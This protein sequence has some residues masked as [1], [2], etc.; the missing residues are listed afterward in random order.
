M[1]ADVVD[2]GVEL[3]QRFA[4]RRV[5]GVDRAVAVRRR[6]DDAVGGAVL[7]EDAHLDHRLRLHLFRSVLTFEAVTPALHDPEV[8]EVESL[9]VAGQAAADQQLQRGVGALVLVAARLHSL[10]LLRQAPGVVASQGVADAEVGHLVEQAA[11]A[12]ELG[13]EQAPLVADGCRVDVL[14]GGFDLDD[15]VRVVTGLV[16]EG[17]GADIGLLR[18]GRHVRDLADEVRD[19]G[20]TRE[21]ARRH[22]RPARL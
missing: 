9:P 17:A 11:A 8:I 10:D 7:A 14:V 15:A 19:I 2:R 13:D 20:Q 5:Q 18:P 16:G 21:L 1:E 6:L 22:D 3:G 12:A 4:H